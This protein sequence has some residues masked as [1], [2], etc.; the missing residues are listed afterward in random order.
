MTTQKHI[1]IYE[2]VI[3]SNSYE[4]LLLHILRNGVLKPTRAI[5]PS[6]GEKVRALS[7]F[8][9]QIRFN[10][11][12]GFPAV[13]TKKLAFK[14]TV[15]ELLWMLAGHSDLATLPPSVQP[16]WKDWADPD[17]EL[18]PI[19]GPQM[20]RSRYWFDVEPL[21]FEPPPVVRTE[22]LLF[23][24]ADLQ[25]TKGTHNNDPI[26]TW[27]K[28]VWRGMLR[29][30]Y[31]PGC[32]SYPAYGAKGVH[33]DASW[34][35]YPKFKEDALRLPGWELKLTYPEDYTL[36]K[37][38]RRASN[39]YG[40]D[41][42]MWANRREQSLNTSTGTPFTAIDPSTQ[43]PV[44]FA[45]IGDMVAEQRV[46]PSAVHR[47]LTGALKTHHGWSDFRYVRP[48]EGKVRRFRELDQLAACVAQLKHN[49]DSRRILMNLWHGPAMDFVGLPCC[50]G[51]V[52]QFNVTEGRLSCQMY[53]RSADAFIGVPVNI[54]SY[55]LLT[56]MVAQVCGLKVAQFIHTFGDLHI[57]ENHLEQVRE[58]IRRAPFAPPKLWL[59][60]S[61]A[62]L[63]DFDPADVALLDYQHHP[64]LKGE[65]AV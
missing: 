54:A 1:D 39:R 37:D 44:L 47:C 17:G 56:H 42:C 3:P 43:K 31:D 11:A 22:G 28:G 41:T 13:T 34:L 29:R 5:L 53:Q 65:V 23:G 58:Q 45:G 50:H 33:V 62:T 38:I 46:N 7:V 14:S 9:H 57:Y 6:T 55:A 30:C 24:V 64:A 60:T 4:G 20:R 18:G 26:D 32:K 19:Y 36:D 52:V 51:S 12:D 25:N 35:Q 49:P 59:N 40:A 16:W 27:L 2:D 61:R 15:A 63:D 21:V 48:E 8:G 10:L